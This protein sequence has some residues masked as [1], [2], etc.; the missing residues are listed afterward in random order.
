METCICSMAQHASPNVIHMR[1]P[2]LAQV[3]R[4]SN[5]ATKYPWSPR[6]SFFI[7]VQDP[8]IC[9]DHWEIRLHYHLCFSTDEVSHGCRFFQPEAI[10]RTPV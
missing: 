6:F 8:G 5:G 1:D 3:M 4:S 7:M 10:L 2:D 9:F